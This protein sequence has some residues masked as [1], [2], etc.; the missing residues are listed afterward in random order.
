MNVMV[1]IRTIRIL[2]KIAKNPDYSRK[3]GVNDTS[4][5][6]SGENRKLKEERRI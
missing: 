3:L 2:E 6:L 5:F 4:V 1:R